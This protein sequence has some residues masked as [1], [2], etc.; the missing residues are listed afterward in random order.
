MQSETMLALNLCLFRTCFMTYKLQKLKVTTKQMNTP[1]VLTSE[2]PSSSKTFKGSLTLH[3]KYK[4]MLKAFVTHT[5]LSSSWIPVLLVY[6]PNW[7]ACWSSKAP[8]TCLPPPC[9]LVIRHVAHALSPVYQP[10]TPPSRP[11]LEAFLFSPSS[12][13]YP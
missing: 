11:L 7:T 9:C 1:S 10:H 4:R 12:Q 5:S 8:D 6:Q 2:L 13:L 3:Y